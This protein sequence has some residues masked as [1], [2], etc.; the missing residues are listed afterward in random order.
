MKDILRLMKERELILKKAIAKAELEEGSFP[1]GHLRISCSNN[2]PRYYKMSR[3]GDTKGEYIVK[4]KLDE[5]TA[6][7]QKDYNRHFLKTA[8]AELGRLERDIKFFSEENADLLF[9]DL[10]ENRKKLVIPYIPTD[11]QYARQW[12]AKDFK[13][14]PYMPE[15]RV[16]A[17]NRG[18][19]VRSKSEAILADML[20]NLG[21]PYHY[22]KPLRLKNGRI[23]YPDFTL[24]QLHTRKEIY[25]E[26]FGLLEDE[27]YLR[28]ALAKLDEYRDSG[29][30][31]GKNLIFT[32][33]TRNSPL[34]IKGIR[35]ILTEL[36]GVH[37]DIF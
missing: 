27:E 20:Y 1:E 9:Q 8:K 10:S 11:E 25:F 28:N 3:R 21:I 35:K 19:M 24:L 2:R 31:P 37:I 29:I 17:T 34:D 4:E 23:V 36:L 5:V 13:P 14:N 22:E 32:Y 30:Y 18:E 12:L 16:Y 26:H 15:N 33:E 6:L 7:A